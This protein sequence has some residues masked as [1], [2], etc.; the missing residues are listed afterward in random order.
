[1]STKL[2]DL[3]S[4]YVAQNG[5]FLQKRKKRQAGILT[6]DACIVW[7]DVDFFHFAGFDHKHVPLASVSAEDGRPVEGEIKCLSEF[8]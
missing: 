5:A 1:M 7:L 3:K 4:K 6:I 2:V 8:R